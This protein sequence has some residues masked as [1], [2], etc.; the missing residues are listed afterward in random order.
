MKPHAPS[1]D[2]T[3]QATTGFSRSTKKAIMHSTHVTSDAAS[4]ASGNGAAYRKRSNDP[5]RDKTRNKNNVP[6][7]DDGEARDEAC[8]AAGIQ[9]SL[10]PEQQ[11]TRA[12]NAAEEEEVVKE[13]TRLSELEAAKVA[14]ECETEDAELTRALFLSYRQAHDS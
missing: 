13:A 5:L 3:H 10:E 1:L 12:T 14:K 6:A 7:S 8:V 11:S 9:M 4:S 2:V